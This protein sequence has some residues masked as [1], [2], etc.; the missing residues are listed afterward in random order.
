MKM[1]IFT[2]PEKIYEFSHKT[3]ARRTKQLWEILV[4][5]TKRQKIRGAYKTEQEVVDYVINNA[6]EICVK[7]TKYHRDQI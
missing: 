3:G 2:D 1:S 4:D 6:A 7:L 5:E